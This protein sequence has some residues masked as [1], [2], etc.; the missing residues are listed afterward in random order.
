MLHTSG[1]PYYADKSKTQLY[2]ADSYVAA[3]G[4]F[5]DLFAPEA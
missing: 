2:L 3:V 5:V 1:W 4:T